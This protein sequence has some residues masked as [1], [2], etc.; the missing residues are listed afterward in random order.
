MKRTACVQLARGVVCGG[1][2]LGT[3]ALVAVWQFGSLRNLSLYLNGIDYVVDPMR[4]DVGSGT[5]G[6]KRTAAIHIRNLGF[7]PI[8][9]VGLEV[10]CSCVSTES[11]PLAVKPREIRDFELVVSLGG[12]NADFERVA[13][14]FFDNHGKL[15]QVPIRIT[16]RCIDVQEKPIESETGG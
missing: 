10:N 7:K 12:A 5:P 2:V 9:V 8:Q 3:L 13:M 15:R 16:G 4:V 14:L 6:E 11:L 1:V